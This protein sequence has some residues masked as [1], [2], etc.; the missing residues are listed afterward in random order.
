MFQSLVKRV[1][2]EKSGKDAQSTATGH[3]DTP[4]KPV[5]AEQALQDK[6]IALWKVVWQALYQLHDQNGPFH[7]ERLKEHYV[8][9]GMS[10]LYRSESDDDGRAPRRHR[11]HGVLG[12]LGFALSRL[13]PKQL[14][15]YDG[16]SVGSLE[17]VVTLLEAYASQI[18]ALNE[19]YTV[20]RKLEV[21]FRTPTAEDE[22]AVKEQFPP[23]ANVL[24]K[25]L[26]H[27]DA[28]LAVLV[29]KLSDE[30]WEIHGNSL[31]HRGW[32]VYDKVFPYKHRGK[33]SFNSMKVL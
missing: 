3:S 15:L 31:E 13:G 12:L 30:N 21:G 26:L 19:I 23:L 27:L 32:L 18:P 20:L 1:S 17:S 16:L 8:A 10:A 29:S 9:A 5:S 2:S 24:A 4:E 14:R 11:S 7:A 22:Q 25:H 28:R 6:I 33:S